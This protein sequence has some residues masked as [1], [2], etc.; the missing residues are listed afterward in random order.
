MAQTYQ[1][2]DTQYQ[3]PDNYTDDQVTGILSKQGIIGVPAVAAQTPPDASAEGAQ[4]PADQGLYVNPNT[5][6]PRGMVQPG[7]IDLRKLPVIDNGDGSYST[8]YSTSFTDEKPESRTF[9]KDVLV[10][11]IL[12]GKRLD[13]LESDD[14]AKRAAA[15]DALKREYYKTG[16]HLGVFQPGTDEEYKSQKDPATAYGIPLHNDFAAGKIPGFPVTTQKPPQAPQKPSDTSARSRGRGPDRHRARPPYR[17]D[18]DAAAERDAAFH[19]AELLTLVAPGKAC[20]HSGEA[21]RVVVLPDRGT[22]TAA[23]RPGFRAPRRAI[24][25]CLYNRAHHAPDSSDPDHQAGRH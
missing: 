3:F 25:R 23:A 11:G 12:N 10:R 13:D 6:K 9:G 1:V 18:R 16:K 24:A 2:G 17:R 14:Q 8:V 22:G 4:A 15:V 21:I 7:N 19:R 20:A 5:P